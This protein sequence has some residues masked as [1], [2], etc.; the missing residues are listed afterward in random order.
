MK[1][2]GSAGGLPVPSENANIVQE[3]SHGSNKHRQ[4]KIAGAREVV[5]REAGF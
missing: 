4:P 5:R 3:I 1:A 2:T